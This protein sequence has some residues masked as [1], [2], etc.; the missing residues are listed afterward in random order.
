MLVLFSC[1]VFAGEYPYGAYLNFATGESRF[2][3]LGPID[4]ARC[5][6]IGE[7]DGVRCLK[8]DPARG[9]YYINVDVDDYYIY[10]GKQDVYVTVEYYDNG[11]DS[12]AVTYDGVQGTWTGGGSAPRGDTRRWRTHTFKFKDAQFT[13]RD[14]QTDFRINNHV[15]KEPL[16]VRFIGVTMAMIELAPTRS[17]VS[18]D[19]QSQTE[20]KIYLKDHWGLPAK[21]GEVRLSADHGQISSELEIKD[22]VGTA[23]FRSD[24]TPGPVKIEAATGNLSRTA[25][26]T[27][28]PTQGELAL[29][30]TVVED[31]EAIGNSWQSFYHSGGAGASK[32]SATQNPVYSGSG[33]LKIAYNSTSDYVYLECFSPSLRLPGAP[34]KLSIWTRGSNGG[35][36]KLSVRLRDTTGQIFQFDLGEIKGDAW[37]QLSCD[38]SD[39]AK[40]GY[41][42]GAADGIIHYPVALYAL[43]VTD[44]KQQTEVFLDRL[45]VEAYVGLTN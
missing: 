10:G 14:G 1:L 15:P 16:Y 11:A 44:G 5:D 22:G 35:E 30:K 45:E 43:V 31:F 23:V 36:L 2:L 32:L 26:L 21:D 20:V 3:K 24:K 13:N 6:E 29:Q 4:G 41:W 9:K 19:G 7:I 34:K 39:P 38:V 18:A 28:L 17:F 40:G 42:S 27:Q 12:V 33:A 8:T 25:V 37:R